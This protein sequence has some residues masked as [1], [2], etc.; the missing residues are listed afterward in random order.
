M[1]WNAKTAI[2]GLSGSGST[3][4]SWCRGALGGVANPV[5]PHRPGDVFD[6]LLAQILKDKGQPVAHLVIDRTGDQHPAGI[7]QGFDP[8][9]DVD[10]IAI[11]VVGLDDDVA[12][13]DADAQFDA[14]FR[15]DAS[16]PL[17]HR[18]LHRDRAAHRIDDARKFDQHAV[19]GALDDPA[20]VLGDLRIDELTAQRFEAFVRAFLVRSCQPRIPHHIGSEDRGETAGLAHPASP[21]ARRRPERNSSRWSG[22]RR[23][24]ASGITTGVM[25][26]IFVTISRASS[27]RPICA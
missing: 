25:A 8:H 3:G 19:A 15:P 10:P 16:V 22:L 11:K 6:L 2:D 4:W 1:F 12:E 20:A 27:S 21:A 5:D 23:K 24:L 17:G 26:R 7:G 9:G 18:L 13:V 14:A